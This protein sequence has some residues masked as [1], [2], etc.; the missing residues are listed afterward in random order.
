MRR[1][2]AAWALGVALAL[3]AALLLARVWDNARIMVGLFNWPFQHDESESMIVAE[4]LLLDHGVNI[5]AKLTPQQ[6]IAAPYPPL[7][8]L[9]NWPAI[10]LLGATFKVG[11]AL[12]LAATLGVGGLLI[13]L[14][15]RLTGD[16]SA[17]IIAALAWGAVGM[18]GFWG[19][20]VKP[21]MLTV[22]LGLGGL[23]WLLRAAA[24]QGRIWGALPLFWAAFYSKQTAIAAAVAAC[25]W[26]I[27]RD[28]R[29]GVIF[30]AIYAAGAVA[31][32]LL[33]NWWTEGGYFYHEI[34]VHALPWFPAA[35]WDAFRNWAGTYWPLLLP[36]LLGLGL[37]LWRGDPSPPPPPLRREGETLSHSLNSPSLFRRG[38]WGVRPSS[39]PSFVGEGLGEMSAR[40][41]PAL[42]AAGYAGMS[43]IMSSG[44]G[45]LG[46]NHNHLLDLTAALCWGL[47][48]GVAA[49]R[50]APR[51]GGRR[52]ATGV[53]LALCAGVVALDPAPHWLSHEFRVL[54]RTEIAGMPNVAQYTS[55]TAGPIYSTDLSVLLVTDKWRIN[56]WT[57]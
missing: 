35:Y 3:L 33:L 53:M 43:L 48:L 57:T 15:R 7:Y 38:R 32:T 24:G 10:H 39:S 20:L 8:Y 46:G 12:S 25:V 30:S 42:L 14:T 29:R 5:Y 18:V 28:W 54:P 56:L 16:W 52:L 41:S 17:G 11:R 40:S 27:L 23:L 21:D 22:A 45:T 31:G 4:T 55:N 13:A 34:T 36:G 47:G 19:V 2:W 6:F 49:L 44:A 37:A 50:A 51:S 26:L 9:L 1:D